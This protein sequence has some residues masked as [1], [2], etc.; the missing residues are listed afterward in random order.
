MLW[1]CLSFAQALN[2]IAK[3]EKLLNWSKVKH[4][5]NSR[6]L[7]SALK[8]LSCLCEVVVSTVLVLELNQIFND[9]GVVCFFRLLN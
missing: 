8:I 6:G 7:S 1:G 2:L 4:E 3:A 9:Y 5:K